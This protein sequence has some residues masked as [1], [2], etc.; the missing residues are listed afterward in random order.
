M[1][2]AKLKL[3]SEPLEV[4]FLRLSRLASQ[5]EQSSYHRDNAAAFVVDIVACT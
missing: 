4:M 3:F 5:H 2:T 1:Q